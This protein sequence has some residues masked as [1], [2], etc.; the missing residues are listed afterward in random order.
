MS[1]A[2]LAERTVE[3]APSDHPRAGEILTPA[4]LGLLGDIHCRFDAR[5]RDLLAARLDVQARYDAGELPDF[6]A[7]TA[8]IRSAE[9]VVAPAPADLQDRRVEITGPTSRKMVINALNSGAKTFMADFED[10]TAPTWDNLIDGQANK[11]D[12]WRGT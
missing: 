11:I 6:R 8:D 4:A 3:A 1:E 7:D 10:S 5:R 2:L 12:R 9:W